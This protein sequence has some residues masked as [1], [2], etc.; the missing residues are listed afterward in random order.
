[1]EW[2]VPAQVSPDALDL[3]PVSRSLQDALGR[4]VM[5]LPEALRDLLATI[6]VA[7]GGMK[8]G[9]LARVHGVSRIQAAALAETLVKRRLVQEEGGSYR[10]THRV[11]ADMMREGLSSVRR[12][13]LH[14]ALALSL[15]AAAGTDCTLEMATMMARHAERGGLPALAFRNALLASELLSSHGDHADALKWL[16][17]ASSS[18]AND[19]ERQAVLAETARVLERAGWLERPVA[20]SSALTDEEMQQEDLDL[21]VLERRA[22]DS[23]AFSGPNRRRRAPVGRG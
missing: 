13:E 4:K 14:R 11:I 9:V 15:E 22:P 18:A 6:A 12:Q 5:I 1:M 7:G 2:K 16:D 21:G 8:I 23:D 10:C 3:V 17:F 20:A 19:Q